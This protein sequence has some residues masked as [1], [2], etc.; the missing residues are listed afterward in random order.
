[1]LKIKERLRQ[2][3]KKKSDKKEEDRNKRLD[4]EKAKKFNQNVSNLRPIKGKGD[5]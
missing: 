2:K 4:P 3:K 1:M 5:L